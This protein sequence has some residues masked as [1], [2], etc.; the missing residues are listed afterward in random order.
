MARCL[1]QI[2]RGRKRIVLDAE[3]LAMPNPRY[4]M[5][6]NTRLQQ[7]AVLAEPLTPDL[8][9]ELFTDRLREH[10][11]AQVFLVNFPGGSTEL[12]PTMRDELDALTSVAT[13]QGVIAADFDDHALRKYCF[14]KDTE[15]SAYAQEAQR[16]IEFLQTLER[17]RGT[18]WV[19]TLRITS[20]FPTLGDAVRATKGELA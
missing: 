2:T 10:P 4:S 15:A 3:E 17:D 18:T 5:E 8:W 14:P 9:Q 11:L 16:R 20:L 13:V 1:A 19:S 6:L 12:F 7:A